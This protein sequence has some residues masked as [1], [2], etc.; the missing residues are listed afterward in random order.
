MFNEIVR[1]L[2]QSESY[3][4]MILGILVVL[5]VGILIY[6]NFSQINQPK[7]QTNTE[8]TPGVTTEQKDTPSINSI[9]P[10]QYTVANGDDLWVIA[11]KFYKDP[12]KWTE[13]AQAN[14]LTQPDLIHPG[15]VLTIPQLQAQSPTPAVVGLPNTGISG[16]EEVDATVPSNAI[17]GTSYT[18]KSGDNLWD[19]AVR[20]YG[21]GYAVVKI[22]K[23]NN[24]SNANLVFEG[25]VLS[26]PR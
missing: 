18:V 23:A 20:A 21:D 6:R 15:N 24:I 8:I 17:S 13:I 10:A 4:S 16:T 3:V 9:L 25:N 2:K 11:D 12:Y 19:I 1:R 22:I 5:V 26:I 14:N 7:T